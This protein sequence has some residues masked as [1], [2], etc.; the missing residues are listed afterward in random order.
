MDS[1]VA[2]GKMSG[3]GAKANYDRLMAYKDKIGTPDE[4][5]ATIEVAQII[6]F[7]SKA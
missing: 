4:G 2:A 3:A 5:A 7:L 6:G 1:K